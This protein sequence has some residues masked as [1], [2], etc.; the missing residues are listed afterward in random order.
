[1]EHAMQIDKILHFNDLSPLPAEGPSTMAKQRKTAIELEVMI[2]GQIN[3][4]TQL[5]HHS[6]DVGRA[7]VRVHPDNTFGWRVQVITAPKS[8]DPFQVAAERIASGLRALYDLK[9]KRLDKV[10]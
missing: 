9:S 7:V 3:R 10:A 6:R 4:A 1:M 5:R 2:E 8:V